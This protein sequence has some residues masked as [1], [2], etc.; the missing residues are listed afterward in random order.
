[1]SAEKAEIDLLAR[2]SEDTDIMQGN[3]NKVLLCLNFR[4]RNG[5]VKLDL[6]VTFPG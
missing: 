1:M 4:D 6:T 2:F 5:A 3:D